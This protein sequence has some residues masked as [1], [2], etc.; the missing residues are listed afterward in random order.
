MLKI[1]RFPERAGLWYLD[2]VNDYLPQ[3]DITP[4]DPAAVLSGPAAAAMEI[5]AIGAQMVFLITGEGSLTGTPIS[6]LIK[7]T[8][9]EITYGK[10]SDD[11]DMLLRPGGTDEL[12]NCTAS[13]ADGRLAKSELHGWKDG[14]IFASN[15]DAQVIG[16]PER[17][18]QK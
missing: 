13:I 15:Q 8:A 18:K 11:I 12:L 17:N 5:I 16:C 9:N 14:R 3:M 4:P 2:A 7:L 10:L 1:A 6:P